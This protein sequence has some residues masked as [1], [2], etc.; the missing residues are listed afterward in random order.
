VSSPV[1]LRRERIFGDTIMAVPK[2]KTSKSRRNQRRA[3]DFLERTYAII[4]P[5][6]GEAVL[7][8]RACMACG[9]YRGRKVVEVAESL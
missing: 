6:C 1:I 3:H 7:R 9:H 2:K 5:N 8:H 4:C